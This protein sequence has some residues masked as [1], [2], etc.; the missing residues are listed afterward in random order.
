MLHVLLSILYMGK[1]V[2]ITKA[3]LYSVAESFFVDFRFKTWN[4]WISLSGG[5][6]K[7]FIVEN[8]CQHEDV[9]MYH[10]FVPLLHQSLEI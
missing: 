5:H 3:D 1:K 4:R 6:L 9:Y 2:I 7:Q 10:I 8:A